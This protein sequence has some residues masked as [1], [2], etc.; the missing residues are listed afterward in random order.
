MCIRD[1]NYTVQ[2]PVQSTRTESYQLSVPYFAVDLP[3]D[4][5][6]KLITELTSGLDP[7]GKTEFKL[8]ELLQR[9]A[10]TWGDDVEVLQLE[11]AAQKQKELSD[12]PEPAKN[13][14][15]ELTE[16]AAQARRLAIVLSNEPKGKS[17][18]E[19][20]KKLGFD[21]SDVLK[22]LEKS[23]V[24]RNAEIRKTRTWKRVKAVPNTTRLMVGDKDELDLTG[25]Q[26]NVQVDGFRA[27]VLIDCF[28]YNDRASQLEGNFKLRLPDDASL[29]YFAFGES[30]YDLQAKGEL[31]DSEFLDDG[32]QFVS[33]GAPEIREARKDAWANVKE[34]RMVPREKAAH[35]YRETVRRKVDPALVEWSGA[36]VFNARVFP[37]AP[38]KLCLLYTSPSP[39]DATLSRM[40]SSA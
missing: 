39:R 40:P 28:Y 34:A 3:E 2:V 5:A 25:M 1:R 31:A 4:K 12:N 22:T 15:G 23:L 11:K 9:S 27:R 18:E 10:K 24:K 35:A 17:G 32:T 38:R 21:A 7:D 20:D 33:L 6:D 8:Q 36:G 14:A 26:V 37:L 29:Y 13:A 16:Q 19:A 30:A